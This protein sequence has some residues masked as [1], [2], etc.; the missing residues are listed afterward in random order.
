MHEATITVIKKS[1][2][3]SGKTFTLTTDTGDM[4]SVFPAEAALFEEGHQY[5][6]QYTST[7]FQGKTYHTIKSGAPSGAAKAP[8]IPAIADGGPHMGMWERE[9]FIALR[10]GM[11]GAEIRIMG[12]EARLIARDIVRTNLDAK[13]SD[14]NDTLEF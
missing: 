13:L 2:S 5:T 12:I 8:S 10:A 3:K 7:D 9:A 4:F 11:T 1:P 14:P 6:V